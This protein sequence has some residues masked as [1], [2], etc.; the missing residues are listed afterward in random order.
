MAWLTSWWSALILFVVPLV[1]TLGLVLRGVRRTV[2]DADR[3]RKAQ[4]RR[5]MLYRRPGPRVY[6]L[7]VLGIVLSCV[8]F[9]S[10]GFVIL[11]LSYGAK[12]STRLSVWVAPAL[13]WMALFLQF[14]GF[15][16]QRRHERRFL[17]RLEREDHLICPDCHYSLAGHGQGGQCPECGYTFTLESLVDDWVDVKKLARRRRSQ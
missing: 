2:P 7:F 9:I 15:R 11:H 17:E 3:R 13:L 14:V 8:V 10:S 1:I 16:A 5:S 4:A 12:L 6:A